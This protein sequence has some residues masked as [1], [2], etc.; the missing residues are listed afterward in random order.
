MGLQQFNHEQKMA[1]LVSAAEVGI[2]HVLNRLVFINTGVYYWRRR[3]KSL[4]K[5]TFYLR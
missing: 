5:Q 4:S 1:I 2:K 3:L